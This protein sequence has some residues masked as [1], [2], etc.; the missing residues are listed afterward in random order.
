[1]PVER[2]PTAKR[3]LTI[4]S[5][6]S[7]GTRMLDGVDGR[8]SSARRFR[9]LML[10]FGGELGGI[11]NLTEGE[12]SLVRQAATITIRAEQLQAAIV[13]GEAVNPDELIRLSNTAR[14]TLASIAPRLPPKATLTE[15]L[16]KRRDEVA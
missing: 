12:R 3:P 6:V 4:C 10:S 13:R 8:S 16:T 1:M 14:R 5:A 15:Y 7:N 2:S 9:D 11:E